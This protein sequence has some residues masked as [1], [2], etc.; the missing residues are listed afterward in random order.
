MPRAAEDAAA[1]AG[2]KC[3]PSWCDTYAQ[4]SRGCCSQSR[5]DWRISTFNLRAGGRHEQLS[6][7]WHLRFSRCH[8]R[9]TALWSL[10]MIALMPSITHMPK[11]WAYGT[12]VWRGVYICMH[13][14]VLCLITCVCV[15]VC[16]CVCACLGTACLSNFWLSWRA[17]YGK[18]LYATRIY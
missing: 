8:S 3:S 18:V 1:S 13:T 14:C 15:C 17:Y 11:G 6:Y 5:V 7:A 16:V 9:V 10:L 4:S 12:W 2:P